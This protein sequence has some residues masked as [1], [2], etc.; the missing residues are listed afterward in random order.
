MSTSSE[1]YKVYDELTADQIRLTRKLNELN[2]SNKSQFETVLAEFNTND[3]ELAEKDTQRRGRSRNLSESEPFKNPF[4]K[5]IDLNKTLRRRS[6]L[7][8]SDLPEVWKLPFVFDTTM[9]DDEGAA[10]AAAQQQQQ[11]MLRQQNLEDIVRQLANLQVQRNDPRPGDVLRTVSNIILKFEKTNTSNFLESVELALGIA[12][13]DEQRRTVLKFAKQRVKG[14]AAIENRTYENFADFKSDVLS[15]FKPKRS[16]TEVES[17]IARL[18]QT[19]KESVDDFSKR[20][21]ELKSEYEQASRAE[22]AAV[23]ANLD[24]VRLAEMEKKMSSAFINGL[25]ENVLKFISQRPASLAEA[26]TVAMEAESVSALRYQNRK[27]EQAKEPNSRDYNQKFNRDKSRRDNNRNFDR[28]NRGNDQGDR[29]Y[30]NTHNDNRKRPQGP[31]KCYECGSEDHLKPDCPKLKSQGEGEAKTLTAKK[32]QR[33]DFDKE[34]A[35]PKNAQPCGAS[36]SA[37]ALKVKSR[38]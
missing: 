32:N 29:R 30:P 13:N 10:A 34:G 22:R 36:V 28:K 2:L 20:T 4:D 9:S 35:K 26:V 18:S 38:R 14:S 1:E 5:K 21:F 17:L 11:E 15:I 16:V 12:N 8:V 23:N 24:D 27:L 6:L 7:D 19:Q 37:R 33:R 25:K 3:K 31:P